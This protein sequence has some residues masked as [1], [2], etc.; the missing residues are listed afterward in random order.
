MLEAVFA[1]PSIN[2]VVSNL[3]LEELPDMVRF[4]KDIGFNIS[5]L[6]VELLAG[7]KDG[8]RNWEAR[9]IRHRP[10]MGLHSQD[11]PE[12]VR[13]RVDKAYDKIIAMKAEGM[14]I[15][16]STPYLEASRN[17]L[18]SGEFPV[19]GCDAGRLYFSIAPNGQFTICHRTVQQHIQFL[20]PDFE[21]YFH[22]KIYERRRLVEVGNC[23]GCMR[24][25]W[26]DTSSMFRTVRG[27]FETSKMVMGSRGSKS[28]TLEEAQRWAR[29]ESVSIVPESVSAK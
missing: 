26:I 19:G 23:E 25:C 11:T 8:I 20:D 15:L 3:N 5:F 16:N 13:R 21:E 14:P 2:C 17:Y 27:F 18:K 22:S 10:E 4:A 28:V 12:S 24:A 1:M 6:P 9:F 7:A 29:R